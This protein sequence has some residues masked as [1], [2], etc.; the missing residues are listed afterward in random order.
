MIRTRFAPSP[1]GYLHI[2]GA[3]TA[4]FAWAFARHNGG[5][6]ILR[7]EDT[8][9]DRS[10]EASVF[11]IL[12]GMR[13]LGLNWDDGPYHQM[14][15]L[16]RYQEVAESLLR[17]GKAY[18]CYSSREELDLLRERQRAEGLKPRY[19]GRWRPVA[20]AMVGH[21]GLK[22]D[23]RILDIGCGKGFLLYE[24]TQVLPQAT[25]AGIDISDYAIAHAKEEVRDGLTVGSVA[26]RLPYD[27]SS[28]DFVYSINT[29]HNL[30]N[31]ELH[32]ALKE[33]ERVSRRA[34]HVTIES[35]RDEIEKAN[36]LYWQL[37]CRAFMKPAEWEWA[38]AQAG[39]TGDYG[40]IY[41]S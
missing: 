13:W 5:K 16:A 40:C 33:V 6:F 30:Y 28:F 18:Y 7:I 15:R 27:T 23:A 37:T 19:D 24:F 12:E 41:F 14:D 35:Y 11:A 4:L 10:T 2:G 26:D 17:S 3:R 22:P 8:D 34:A 32:A 36:L 9:R 38:F 1:T 39:Y 21:Y 20:E 29:L 31:Y 25:V